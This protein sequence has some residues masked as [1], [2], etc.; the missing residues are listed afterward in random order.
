[1]MSQDLR[2]VLIQALQDP[3]KYKSY[4]IE[5]NIQE[6]IFTARRATCINF[7]D[8]DL[9]IGTADLT[10]LYTLPGHVTGRKSAIFW[11]TR[12]P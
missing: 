1:M 7:T 2:E 11:S 3:E 12:G 6:V 8:D 10:V 5:Q 9:L 4:F